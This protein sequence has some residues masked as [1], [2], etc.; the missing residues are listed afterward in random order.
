MTMT[1]FRFLLSCLSCHPVKKAA[2][3]FSYVIVFVKPGLVGNDEGYV[4]PPL[5]PIQNE[6]HAR[7]VVQSVV[8]PVK[9]L[10]RRG[11]RHAVAVANRLKLR[12]ASLTGLGNGDEASHDLIRAGIDARKV[13]ARLF[14]TP[15]AMSW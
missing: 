10:F 8:V 7:E 15:G 4:V 5:L 2:A 1:L 14:R 13:V 6:A 9:I 11:E 12:R 3:A